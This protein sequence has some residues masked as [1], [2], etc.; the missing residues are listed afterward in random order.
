MNTQLLIE[1]LSTDVPRVSQYAVAQRMGLGILVGCVASLAL[2]IARLGVR[3]DMQVAIHGFSFWVRL[4]YT[5]SLGVCTL[6]AVA[7]LARS[8]PASLR[9]LWLL[10]APV[11]IL[12]AVG[13]NELARTPAGGWPAMWLG[14]SW[15]SCPWLVL[16]L[17]VPIFMGVLWSFRTLAP[18]RLRAAGATAGLTA[19]AWAATLYS[20]HCPEPA[21]I[22]TLTW[23]NLGIVLATGIGV[24]L[25][26]RLL[27]W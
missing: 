20:L 1:R 21:A 27:R 3:P 6:H 4:A 2:V 18:T 24:L 26:P 17:A 16:A 13:I 8:A 19:G 15:M 25:G 22:F 12:T 14:R 11:L 7:Q 10:A 23:Y 9:S 5:L